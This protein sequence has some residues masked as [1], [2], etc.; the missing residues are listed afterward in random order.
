VSTG[1][2]RETSPI[3]LASGSPRRKELLQSTGI[4]FTI[5]ASRVAEPAPTP[6]ESSAGYALRMARLKAASVAAA[7]PGAFILSADTVVA[8]DGVILG[9]PQ[10]AADARRMLGMLSGRAHLA[11]TGCV[12]AN[13]QGSIAWEEA[14]TSRVTFIA[15]SKEMIAAYAATGEPLDKAGGYAIQGLGAFMIAQIEGSYTNVVGLPVAEVVR[16]LLSLGAVAPRP[17]L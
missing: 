7:H 15:L 4:G 16:A 11:A 3:I 6:N 9:K 13:P 10:D 17:A 12:L 8:V 14:F 1:A 2:F 5:I